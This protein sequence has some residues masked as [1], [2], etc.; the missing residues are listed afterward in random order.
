MKRALI[1][2]DHS[3]V[4]RGLR[5]ILGR[6]FGR[7]QIA[8]AVDSRE[9]V[10]LLANQ[11]WDLLLLDINMPGRSGLDLLVDAKRLRPALPVLVL[12]AYPEEEFALRAFRLGASGYL[13]KQIAPDEL[14]LA[15][16]KILGGGKY[17]MA[18]LA[19]G[20]AASLGDRLNQAPHEAL[21]SRELEVLRLVATGR[22]IK[23]IAAGMALSETTIA[24]YRARVSG[25]LGL[26]T[27]IE[28][29]RYAH[30]HGLVNS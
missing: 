30:K 27:T 1:V 24:T 13:N 3:V 23:E 4:R 19:E 14:L 5:D 22:T 26:R 10:A 6:E 21:S 11:I 18:S 20:L 25:K 16:K 17:V 12:S 7:L 28:I 15:V 9:A 2:D 29:T 8:E